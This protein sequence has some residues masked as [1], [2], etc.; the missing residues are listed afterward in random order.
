MQDRRQRKRGPKVS[1]T[2]RAAIGQYY[3]LTLQGLSSERPETL[4]DE[5]DKGWG[6][7]KIVGES[8]LRGAWMQPTTDR[9]D[10]IE[11]SATGEYTLDPTQK[12]DLDSEDIKAATGVIIHD[13]PA[14]ALG[15]RLPSAM[16]STEGYE[17]A[18]QGFLDRRRRFTR[19]KVCDGNVVER[20]YTEC[21]ECTLPLGSLD[22]DK[23]NFVHCKRCDSVYHNDCTE[24]RGRQPFQLREDKFCDNAG[25]PIACPKCSVEGV[26]EEA[27]LQATIKTVDKPIFLFKA[28]FDVGTNVLKA[29]TMMTGH[30]SRSD[31]QHVTITQ[32]V[33]SCFWIDQLGE[34]DPFVV[35]DTDADGPATLTEKAVRY[36]PIKKILYDRPTQDA[37]Q[38]AG[39]NPKD[40]LNSYFALLF[41]QLLIERKSQVEAWSAAAKQGVRADGE[42]CVE[43]SLSI[44]APAGLT[45]SQKAPLETALLQAGMSFAASL[46]LEAC[47]PL[48]TSLSEPEAAFIGAHN[49]NPW[50]QG[51][52][53]RQDDRYMIIDLGGSTTV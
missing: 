16:S 26:E 48:V 3:G 2:A 20:Q 40:C 32:S 6:I 15:R 1:D 19:S 5:K 46:D 24:G 9:S 44:A 36:A 4:G 39:T 51:G 31:D 47:R 7:V 33:A 42:H 27:Y 12:W 8:P 45:A 25:I 38:R 43:I 37:L 11:W 34:S 14:Y 49:Q 18:S 52:D 50:S 17:Q 35:V 28:C 22:M 21:S 29:S 10:C 23:V 30:G 53:N 13:M 41:K